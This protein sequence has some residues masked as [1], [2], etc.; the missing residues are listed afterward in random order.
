MFNNI[1]KHLTVSAKEK[2]GELARDQRG[3]SFIEYVIVAGLVAIAAI[4]AF[5]TFGGAVNTQIQAETNA[6]N[7]MG[8]GG[9][10][11]AGAAAGAAP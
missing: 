8:V 6:I 3:A 2:A 5:R 9:A 10:G 4:G 7:G 1:R 11:A